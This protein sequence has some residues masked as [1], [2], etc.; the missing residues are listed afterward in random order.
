MSLLKSLYNQGQ[1]KF[2]DELVIMDYV[3][4]NNVL[5]L[6]FGILKKE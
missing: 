3:D 5:E 2:C 6:L 1:E 4:D